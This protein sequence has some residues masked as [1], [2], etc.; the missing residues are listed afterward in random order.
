M[1]IKPIERGIVDFET[2]PVVKTRPV[3]FRCS[4]G[5]AGIVLGV[6]QNRRRRLIFDHAAVPFTKISGV[7]SFIANSVAVLGAVA[8]YTSKSPAPG[9]HGRAVRKISCPGRVYT[10]DSPHRCAYI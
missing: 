10:P 1:I 7:I 2:I 9:M 6:F 3:I 8:L 4:H 5:P